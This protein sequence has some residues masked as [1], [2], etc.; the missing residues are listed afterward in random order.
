VDVLKELTWF[1][2]I[3]DQHRSLK[4]QQYGQRAVVRDLFS[5]YMGA[6]ASQ[7]HEE[8]GTFPISQQEQMHDVATEKDQVRLVA[9]LISSMTE[10]QLMVTHRKL[11]GIEPGS[12]TD[13]M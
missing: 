11:T 10:R 3:D 12:I 13:L 1:Y 8:L 6:G 4:V 2:V 7:G 9:D 5:I